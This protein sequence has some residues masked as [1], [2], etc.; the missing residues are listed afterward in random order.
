M[1]KSISTKVLGIIFLIMLLLSASIM[2]VS[3]MNSKKQLHED[4]SLQ[5]KYLMNSVKSDITTEFANHE[6]I[7]ENISKIYSL[8]K[9]KMN[10]KDYK[11]L[12]SAILPLNPNTLGS[13]IW[14]EPNKYKKSEKYFGPYIYKDGDKMVYTTDYEAADYDYPSQDWYTGTKNVPL[15]KSGELGSN[16]TDPYYDESTGITM[17]TTTVPIVDKGKFIGAVSAD[18]DLVTIQK[19]ISDITIG[20]TGNVLLVDSTGMIIAGPDKEQV[21]KVNVADLPQYKELMANYDVEGINN[22]ETEINGESYDIFSIAMPKTSWKIIANVPENE[23][24]SSLTNTIMYM[25]FVSILAIVIAMIVVYLLLRKTII[26]PIGLISVVLERLADFNLNSGEEGQEALKYI[27]NKDEIGEMARSTKKMLDSLR[28]IVNNILSHSSNTAAM[29]EELTATAQNTNESAIEVSNA[30]VNIAEGATG[31]AND[32]TE[33]ALSVEENSRS[34]HD[35]IEML[36]E[37]ED[38]TRDIDE[39]KNEGKDALEKLLKNGEENKEAAGYVNQIILETN[40][41]AENISKASEMIQSIADQTNLLALNAAIEAAR[42]GEAGK[43]FAVVAEEIRKLAEDSTKFTEEIRTIIAGLKEKAQNAV[44]TMADV[45]KIVQEQDNQTVI[46]QNKFGDIE[47]AVE[48]SKTI[49]HNI[50]INS[51]QIEE[52][53]T[54]II[55][56]IQN[57][58]AIAEENAATTQQASASVETQTQSIN[59]IS[60]AS[61]NLAEIASELQNE[62]SNFK[63]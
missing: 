2:L 33:A 58:S 56:I 39:K 10:R 37:L 32:T 5:M 38:V 46:T 44:D 3:I 57:L 60:S 54:Q 8:N 21:M 14:I 36:R 15:M 12:I 53:N 19:M 50:A 55:G 16:W 28:V 63:F 9:D 40:E 59:D 42:A 41:S 49:V 11:E 26:R 6:K 48:R 20:E 25:V 35:M 47:D 45:A 51:N 24:F 27:E 23:L 22:A 43:G 62:V 1:K 7:A 34:I 17:I 4:I 30:V 13:G 31:Q 52:K 61:V 18:Y 29:A